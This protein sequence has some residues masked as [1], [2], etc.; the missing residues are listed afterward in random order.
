M[1][2]LAAALST[3]SA[4]FK[5][6]ARFGGAIGADLGMRRPNAAEGAYADGYGKGYEDGVASATAQAE[7]DAAARTRIEL[8]LGRL[9]EN[10]E[11]RFEERLRET[12]L[13]LC[14]QTLA[15]LAV[16]PDQLANRVSNALALLRRSE[17]ERTLR[18]HPDDIALIEGRLPEHL[19]VE[20][21][22][23]IE[24]GGIRIETPEGGI[25]DGPA[26]WRRALTEALG[27]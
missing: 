25:E 10:E 15:P 22:P 21:D 8:G 11:Q 27:L 9:A 19:R 24:R 26:E 2:N 7:Q 5:P 4:G 23:A 3:P 13:A 1:S 16:D 12:V 17:D 20:P 6:D 18:L 14:E